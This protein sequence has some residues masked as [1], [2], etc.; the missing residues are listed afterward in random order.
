MQ[1]ESR[2]PRHPFV[3]A[4]WPRAAE[5]PPALR[6]RPPPR[7]RFAG[8]GHRR[9]RPALRTAVVREQGDPVSSE[10]EARGIG[11]AGLATAGARPKPHASEGPMPTQHPATQRWARDRRSIIRNVRPTR[12]DRRIPVC[13]TRP[14]VPKNRPPRPTS[15]RGH[16]PRA[17]TG[18]VAQRR[19]PFEPNDLLRAAISPI[20]SRTET[21]R[22]TAQGSRG[23]PGWPSAN[24]QPFPCPPHTH[25]GPSH[26]VSGDNEGGRALP[27]LK[28]SR[29]L[30]RCLTEDAP[31]HGALG[32]GDGADQHG[33]TQ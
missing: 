22:R 32:G 6:W 17:R 26:N 16:R 4:R 25:A 27:R 24:R 14:R 29:R 20:C 19:E 12:A 7:V 11:R 31:E 33:N 9:T 2:H 21:K 10:P 3:P 28:C 18:H 15:G 13:R 23:S 1:T 5:V 30:T 8:A